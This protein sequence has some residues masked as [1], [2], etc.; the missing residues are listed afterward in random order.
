M[1][2]QLFSSALSKH[3]WRNDRPGNRTATATHQRQHGLDSLGNAGV[4]IKTT[5]TF[6]KYYFD[7]GIW[8]L[9]WSARARARCFWSQLPEE[10]QRSPGQEGLP[11]PR[12]RAHLTQPLWNG[13]HR[14]THTH[15]HTTLP[16]LLITLSPALHL[17]SLQNRASTRNKVLWVS[18]QY[19][20]CHFSFTLISSMQSSQQSGKTSQEG[21]SREKISE[22]HTSHENSRS[23]CS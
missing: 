6:L 19:G 13:S 18:E 23:R 14:L 1:S 9:P 4:G 3:P 2:L 22:G 12:T 8:A 7:Q 21:S 11:L 20:V 10:A 16:P 5:H 15:A 17:F